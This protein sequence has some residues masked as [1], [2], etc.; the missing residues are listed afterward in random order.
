MKTLVWDVDDVLNNLMSDWYEHRWRRENS[1]ST[2]GYNQ[3]SENPP[4]RVL[5]ISMEAYLESLDAFRRSDGR[6]LEPDLEVLRWFEKQGH[7]FRHVALTA[8]PIEFADISAAWVMRNFGKWIR[9]F[10]VIP[11]RSTDSTQDPYDKTKAEFLVRWGRADLVIDDNNAIIESV[12]EIP[13]EAILWPR[14]WNQNKLLTRMNA[15]ESI[16][17]LP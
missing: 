7:R 16:T 4:N 13:L 14:P 5:G 6:S 9:S 17:Q 11:S 12:R 10:H 15:L 8:V 1:R 2:L 3:I